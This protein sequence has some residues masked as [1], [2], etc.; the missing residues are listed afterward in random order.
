MLISD[1]ASYFDDCNVLNSTGTLL[2]KAQLDIYDKSTSE[3]VTATRRT[4]SASPGTASIPENRLVAIDGNTYIAGRTVQDSFQGS[5]FRDSVVLQSTN[6]FSEVSGILALIAATPSTKTTRTFTAWRKTQKEEQR[7]SEF[8]NIYDI[9]F[10]EAYDLSVAE[11]ISCKFDSDT[12]AGFYFVAALERSIEGFSKAVTYELGAEAL[13][14]V[15]YYRSTG[16][17]DPATGDEGY[18]A[19]V[20]LTVLGLRY[21]AGYSLE[22]YSSKK[23]EIGDR[24]FFTGDTGANSKDYLISGGKRYDVLSISDDAFEVTGLR[25]I[26]GRR[27]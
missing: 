19:P 12:V 9:Y 25:S 23:F 27:V 26:H 10:P 16:V 2:F 18:S 14:V 17:Y 1:A 11:V 21:K 8:F 3:G 15:S 13:D 4:L 7:T 24:L 5:P 6:T 20:S 22:S